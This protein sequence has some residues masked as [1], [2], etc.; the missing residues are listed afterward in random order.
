MLRNGSFAT[1]EFTSTFLQDVSCDKTKR[2]GVLKV[3]SGEE[4]LFACDAL[5]HHREYGTVTFCVNSR[6][7]NRGELTLMYNRYMLLFD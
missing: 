7:R 2:H 1:F 4:H 3:R 5:C 6:R